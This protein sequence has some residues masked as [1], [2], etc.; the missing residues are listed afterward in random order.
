MKHIKHT[1]DFFVENNAITSYYKKTRHS[2]NKLSVKMWP[3]CRGLACENEL[4]KY[5]I[6]LS[7]QILINAVC[8]LFKTTEGM[9]AAFQS[10][11]LK[12]SWWCKW[13]KM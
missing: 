7:P 3:R 5:T 10:F 9:P 8:T 2:K 1:F 4:K 13:C 12:S 6:S 11:Q